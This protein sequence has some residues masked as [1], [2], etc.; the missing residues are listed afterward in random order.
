MIYD[1]RDYT[2][3]KQITHLAVA[4]LYRVWAMS[5]LLFVGTA[6]FRMQGGYFFVD[7]T[8]TV[9]FDVSNMAKP[10]RLGAIGTV[11]LPDD[12]LVDGSTAYFAGNFNGNFV[13]SYW[14]Q[15]V[16]VGKPS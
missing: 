14:L 1:V 11:D 13:G 2:S 9:I 8:S 12:L 5:G 4:D 16:A 6:H 15:I 10:L 3:P 7:A